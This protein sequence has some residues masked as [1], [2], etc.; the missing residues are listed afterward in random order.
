MKEYRE[1]ISRSPEETA[2]IA[3]EMGLSLRAAEGRLYRLRPRLRQE[4]GGDDA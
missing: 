3:A 4:L 2:Q 1:Y